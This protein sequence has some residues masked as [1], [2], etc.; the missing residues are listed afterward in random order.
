REALVALRDAGAAFVSRGDD[1]GTHRKERSLWIDAGIDA[2]RWDGYVE[3][4]RGM[5]ATLSM[6]AEMAAYTLTD[7]STLMRHA[8]AGAV[9]ILVEGD[10]PL[11]NPYAVLLLNRER[12][13]HV[14][15]EAALRVAEWLTGEAGQA[16]IASFR[17]EGKQVFFL[18]DRDG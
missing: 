16:A 3:S 12:H 13:P 2:P 9:R 18:L 5:G 17:L 10:P 4:G 14:Q 8:D 7:R 15:H 1:S 11:R 6:A